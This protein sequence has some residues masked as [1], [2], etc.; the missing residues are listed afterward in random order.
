ML[1]LGTPVEAKACGWKSQASSGG[2]R[3]L[4]DALQAKAL[5]S[6]EYRFYVLYDKVYREDVLAEAYG[7][8]RANDGSPGVDGE[9]FGDIE[10]SGRSRWLGELSEDLRLKRYEPAA[11]RRVWIPKSDGSLRPLGIPTVRDRVVQM[12]VLLLLEPIFDGDL[13]P[14]QYAYRANKDALS[15]LKAIHSLVNT[16]HTEVVDADLS[17]Y[18][19]SIPHAELM[20][21]VARRICDG[22]LLALIKSWLVAAVE[23]RGEGGKVVR[24]TRNRDEGRGTPQGGVLSPLLSNLYMRRFV[25]GWKSLGHE[26]RLQAKLINYADDFV[27]LCRGTGVKAMAAMREMMW[28]LKLTV[29]ESKTRLCRLPEESFQFLG[30]TLGRCYSSR[31]G[32]GVFG[33]RPSSK[34]VQSLTATISEWT[35]RSTLTLSVE[36]LVAQLNR[37]LI[38]WAHYFS[39]G[40]VSKAYGMV[41]RH[42]CRRLRRW[43][44]A[45]HKKSTRGYR[46]YS[47]EILHGDYGL[48]DLR[49]FRRDYLQ[50]H[51]LS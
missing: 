17:G 7:R 22:A 41:D 4:Q 49:T 29:N 23:E 26:K 34:K 18:F 15:A 12:A 11:V 24:T 14:E 2:V 42:A 16:G 37:R 1:N 10:S 30:Y 45:K 38:G 50:S 31:T 6:P 8:C 44:C 21:S 5:G 3:K 13:P 33:T 36:D 46:E 19:D 48:I 47:D 43:L 40:F 9:T 28:K 39:L 27:I 51:G 25:L 20:R 32:R 35:S